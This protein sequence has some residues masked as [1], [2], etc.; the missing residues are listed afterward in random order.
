M[1]PSKRLG[2]K[3][4]H[5]EQL[6]KLL[7]SFQKRYSKRIQAGQYIFKENQTAND[8]YFIINGQVNLTKKCL[9]QSELQ[10][11][12][13]NQ[14]N[15]TGLEAIFPYGY[16]YCNAVAATNLVVCAVPKDEFLKV[17]YQYNSTS[18]LI[19]DE[20]YKE[21]NDM[22]EKMIAVEERQLFQ[23]IKSI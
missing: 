11:S 22:E 9:D 4:S 8:I 3:P 23:P 7:M 6:S 20:A 21:I 15:F 2:N 17:F 13:I 19:M 5:H 14:G 16:Y 1:T 10:M 12:I 18:F